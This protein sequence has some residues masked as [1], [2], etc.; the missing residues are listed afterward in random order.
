MDLKNLIFDLGNVIIP[1]A[2]EGHWWK[3][4]FLDIFESP[5]E[6]QQLKND[7]FL[8]EYEKGA[9]DTG[10]FLEIL[11]QH[12][13]PGFDRKNIADRW[14]ALLKEIPGYRLDFLRQLKEK[15]ALF[16]LSN[17]NEIHLNFIIDALV[18]KYG[19]DVLEEI[20]DHCYYSY[21]I[22]EVKPDAEIYLKVLQNQNIQGESTLF[23][24]DKPVN[25]DAAAI[26]GIQ[27][28]HI[29]PSQDIVDILSDL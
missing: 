17:T 9:F 27:I 18:Q 1:L 13:K 28:R 5:D 29:L 6:V 21:Q 2:D 14:N 3:E 8:V 19:H 16:L 10:H 12:L 25:L 4:V 15:Y 26:L 22:A 24:D 20:F 23:I 7:G 11:E